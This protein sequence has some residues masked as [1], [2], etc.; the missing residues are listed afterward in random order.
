LADVTQRW[1][2]LALMFAAATLLG[3]YG[4]FTTRHLVLY[5]VPSSSMQPTV[6]PGDVLLVDAS[7][8]ARVAPSISDIVVFRSPATGHVDYVKRVVA[9]A[10]EVIE[11]HDHQLFTQRVRVAEPYVVI[12]RSTP[13]LL[14]PGSVSLLRVP[15]AHV[16]VL[17]D[18][19]SHSVDSRIFGPVARGLLQG[20]ARAIVWPPGHFRLLARAERAP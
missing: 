6:Q 2:T 7:A 20:R 11:V 14:T 3:S 10:G 9:E 13:D 8:Y 12:D 16:Y 5:R 19:R 18:N 17:G 4:Y 1:R 15:E